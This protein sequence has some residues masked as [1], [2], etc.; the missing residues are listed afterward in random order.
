MELSYQ[1]KLDFFSELLTSSHT[2]YYWCYNAEMELLSSSCPDP[3]VYEALF[4]LGGCRSYL[5]RYIQ[6]ERKPLIL[7]DPVGMMWIVS[8][9][10]TQEQITRI[11]MIG[12]VFIADISVKTFEKKL[13]QGDYSVKTKN[14]FMRILH[15]VP[16][17]SVTTYFQYGQMLHF[18]V[19][20]EKIPTGAF[21]FQNPLTPDYAK[22]DSLP[23]QVRTISESHGTWAAEQ[24]LVRRIED[25]NL[26]YQ[27][28]FDKVAI[29]GSSGNFNLGD[30]LRQAKDYVL[31]FI[32]LA[33]RAA[34]R[35]GL[36]PELSYTLSDF[37]IQ[38]VENAQLIPEIQ[39]IGHTMYRDYITR[40][41]DLK[42][43]SAKSRQVQECMNYIQL[44]TRE[45]ISIQDIA[46][47]FGYTEYYFSKKFKKETG[48]SMKEYI[49]QS[50]ISHAKLLLKSTDEPIQTISENLQFC[51]QSYF[52]ETFRKY[53]GKS[54]GTYRLSSRAE[55]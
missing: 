48:M 20:G 50:R 26:N 33:S 10:I 12:P 17:I 43:S 42:I 9:E 51:S 15:S 30:P 45:E 24:E 55:E 6:K 22:N 49:K 18:T 5:T 2:I 40:V 4:A 21:Q 44:H 47:Q 8:F 35:A 39:E 11:H 32:I 3:S 54:P 25:G 7:S 38:S 16:V 14:S 34:M 1:G 53:T 29:T 23:F 46:A 27:D 41:H 19:T 52:A 36:S 28:A 13:F 31:S 37:Y